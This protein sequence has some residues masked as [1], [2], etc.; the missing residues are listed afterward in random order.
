MKISLDGAFEFEFFQLEDA[1][2]AEKFAKSIDGV[3]YSWKTIG[4]FQ[5]AGKEIFSC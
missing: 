3:I 2:E 4:F 1:Q 5:L